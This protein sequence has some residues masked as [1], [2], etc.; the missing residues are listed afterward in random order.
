MILSQIKKSRLSLNVILMQYLW[1]LI[2]VF[3]NKPVVK[4]VCHVILL[5]VTE[6]TNDVK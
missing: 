2:H 4:L 1:N 6:S 3:I 5:K